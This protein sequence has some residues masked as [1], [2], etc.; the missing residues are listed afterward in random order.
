M[1]KNN[2]FGILAIALVLSVFPI[3]AQA[4]NPLDP[5][6][7]FEDDQPSVINNTNSN[8][9]NSNVNSPGGTVITPGVVPVV[10]SDY[11][12]SYPTYPP[13]QGSLSGSCNVD[14]TYARTGT[15]VTWRANAYGGTGSYSYDWDGTD[16]LNGSGSTLYRSYS[17]SGIKNASVRITSGNQSIRISCS[18]SVTVESRY[19][20]YDGPYYNDRH[21]SYDYYDY[22]NNRYDG[23][24]YDSGPIS[25]ICS[26]SVNFAQVGEYVTWTASV[27]GGSGYYTYSWT[28]SD[29]IYGGDSYT[30]VRYN[31]TGPKFAN[32]TVRSNGRVVTQSCG[33]VNIGIPTNTS[34]Y[35]NTTA[36][37]L[38]VTCYPDKTDVAPSTPITWTATP[39]GGN[40]VYAYS[41]TG[42]DGLI[43]SQ[44]MTVTAYPATGS[45]SATVT[46]TSAGRTVSTTCA[47]SV[48]VNYKQQVARKSTAPVVAAKPA[49]TPEASAQTASSFL[50]LN[51]VP[52]GA[53]AIIV[54]FVLF[55]TV[56]YLLFNK[57]KI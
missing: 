49:A 1:N 47:T 13:Y 46:V 19:D 4:F 40:G 41:W 56:M 55:G 51:N 33:Y 9:V 36:G 29:H 57:S 32:V 27:T 53:V 35:G 12:T 54:I 38:G 23:R 20:D 2:I 7:V 37:T 45:K 6:G 5:F 8:N 11:N 16:G 3:S 24:Y 18:N 28:G 15:T 44:R 48:Q 43:G 25:V 10:Y 17:N 22:S 21:Y 31:A 52:W 42:T 30:N 50:A 26:P 39:T 14:P 34:Y